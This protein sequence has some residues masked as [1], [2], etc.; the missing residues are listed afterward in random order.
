MRLLLH[1]GRRLETGG[2]VM[3]YQM[4]LH[5]QL[6]TDGVCDPH[7]PRGTSTAH[8]VSRRRRG[9]PFKVALDNHR[10]LDIDAVEALTKENKIS[11]G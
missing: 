3:M 4:R 8:W 9:S 1:S 11:G 6:V 10:I 7:A 2:L 5:L